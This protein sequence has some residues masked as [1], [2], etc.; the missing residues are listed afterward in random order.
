MTVYVVVLNWNGK[1]DT[2]TCLESLAQ[3]TSPHQTVVVDNG[4]TDDSVSMIKKTFPDV[5]LVETGENL[6]YAGGNNFGVQFAL[7]QGA[8]HIFILNNDTTVEP[9]IIEA[10]LK[11][12]LPLQGGSARLM[13]DKERLDHLGG[14]WN[15]ELGVFEMIG[16]GARADAWMAPIALDY[17]CG[18]ALFVKAEVFRK[19]GLFDPR[20]FLFWEESDFCHRAKKEGI[21]PTTCPEAILY[22][23]VSASFTG[24]KP[25]TT[26]FW[27]RNRLLWIEKNCEKKERKRLTKNPQRDFYRTLKLYLLKLFQSVFSKKTEER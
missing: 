13:K 24:G 8:D 14:N 3:M 7:D 19:I 22:H 4:S 16:K 18:V 5:H 10:F 2:L 27:W 11:R 17:V 12:D 25:H 9:T 26:Y 15:P 23:K 1:D 21:I 20:F 6:G